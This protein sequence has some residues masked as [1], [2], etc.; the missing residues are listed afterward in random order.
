MKTVRF[1]LTCLSVI[2]VVTLALCSSNSVEAQLPP[3]QKTPLPKSGLLAA[4][5]MS[6]AANTQI[7]DTFGDGDLTGK[8]IPPIT[9]SVFRKGTDRW[10]FRVVNN[11]KDI[12][13]VNVDL[14]QRNLSGAQVKFESYSYT[15][16]PGARDGEEVGS[17]LGT[18]KAELN[19]RSYR[20]ISEERRKKALAP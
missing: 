7:G 18:M 6:G 13:S 8:E 17:G 3:A 1:C 10:A 11:S 9:G 14:I 4:S 5:S 15:L 19:L 16:K 20:N 12:Y 2:A